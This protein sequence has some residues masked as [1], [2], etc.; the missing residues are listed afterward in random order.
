MS[1]SNESTAA[2]TQAARDEVRIRRAPKLPAFMI[3][4]GGVGAIATYIG[5]SLFPID[6][7]VGFAALFGYFALY[8]VTVGVVVGALLALIIDRIG[9]SRARNVM[10]ERE[11]IITPVPDPADSV[12]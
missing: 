7:T 10:V 2:T 4:G 8:G 11:T 6:P 5:T 3:V 1:E 9:L 12:D